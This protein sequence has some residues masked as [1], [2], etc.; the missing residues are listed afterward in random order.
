MELTTV[1]VTRRR[2]GRYLLWLAL[3]APSPAP[4]QTP[5]APLLRGSVLSTVLVRLR[6]TSSSVPISWRKA[7]V[8]ASRTKTKSRKRSAHEESATVISVRRVKVTTE[9][10]AG[11][12]LEGAGTGVERA[13]SLHVF[14]EV[15]RVRGLGAA[16]TLPAEA[17]LI[18]RELVLTLG[19]GNC[20]LA[21][22]VGLASVPRPCSSQHSYAIKPPVAV[23]GL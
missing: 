18:F 19:G 12:A 13:T 23:L 5:G 14:R 4:V 20:T 8:P 7:E 15:L 9:I 10:V 17:Q 3:A 22:W 21:V 2:L 11:R 1:L 16:F 6:T